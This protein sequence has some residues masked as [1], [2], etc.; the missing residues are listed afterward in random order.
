MFSSKSRHCGKKKLLTGID[1]MQKGQ[2]LHNPIDMN[3]PEQAKSQRQ[4]GKVGAV[5]GA[6]GLGISQDGLLLW[7]LK[8][9]ENRQQ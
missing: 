1:Q 6:R 4:S 5:V 2:V 8:N 3:C 7:M 9:S